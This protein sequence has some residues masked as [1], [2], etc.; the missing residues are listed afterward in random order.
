MGGGTQKRGASCTTR[1]HI[2][3]VGSVLDEKRGGIE[4]EM[5][6]V[7][8]QESGVGSQSGELVIDVSGEVARPGVYKLSSGARVEEALAAAG[9]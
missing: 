2:D 5:Q 9:G 1:S 4:T 6:I 3:R 8:S 7:G